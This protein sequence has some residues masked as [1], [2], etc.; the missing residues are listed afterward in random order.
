MILI[1]NDEII[2]DRIR[3]IFEK[4]QIK[5]I[6][7]WNNIFVSSFFFLNSFLFMRI[8][9]KRF[10]VKRV[11]RFI[12]KNR[13][14]RYFLYLSTELYEYRVFSFFIIFFFQ[15]T[16]FSKKKSFDIFKFTNR[17]FLFFRLYVVYIFNSWFIC[18]HVFKAF[19]SF[20]LKKTIFFLIYQLLFEIFKKCLN[21]FYIHHRKKNLIFFLFFF[22]FHCFFNFVFLTFWTFFSNQNYFFCYSFIVFSFLFFQIALFFIEKN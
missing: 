14:I 19:K 12:S 1:F 21:F 13:K 10:D 11:F 5:Q 18:A 2:F 6:F 15:L 17:I 20:F 7:F 8:W 22:S 4:F 3:F 16:L 9:R